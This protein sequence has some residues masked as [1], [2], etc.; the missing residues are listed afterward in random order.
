ML[1]GDDRRDWLL[2]RR[3]WARHHVRCSLRSGMAL[4]WRHPRYGSPDAAVDVRLVPGDWWASR[5]A[6]TAA[7]DTLMKRPNKPTDSPVSQGS[8]CDPQMQQRCPL[9]WEHL[10]CQAYEDGSKREPSTLL[11]FLQDGA[12]KGMLRD[13]DGERCLWVAARSLVGLFDAI[14]G[15]LTDDMADWRPDRRSKGESAPRGRRAG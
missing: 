1:P 13:K 7:A 2:L 14:E 3:T 15:Q 5:P 6:L 11:V 9:L 12:L 8:V 10:T 4:L